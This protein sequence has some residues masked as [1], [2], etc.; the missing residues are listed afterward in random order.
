MLSHV[1]TF[2][3]PYHVLSVQ[4]RQALKHLQCDL[5][6]DVLRYFANL[7]KQQHNPSV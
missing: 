1:S 6:Q 4:E 3:Q 2:L 5:A 7:Q